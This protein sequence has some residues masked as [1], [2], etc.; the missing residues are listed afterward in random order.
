M[1]FN[2]WYFKKVIIV[3]RPE[4]F[5]EPICAQLTALGQKHMYLPAASLVGV[6]HATPLVADLVVFLSPASVRYAPM[7]QDVACVY[8]VGP[9]TAK[10]VEARFK[11]RCHY[12]SEG[13]YH[14]AGLCQDHGFMDQVKHMRHCIILGG[15]GTE[16]TRF[17]ALKAYVELEF[18]TTHRLLPAITMPNEP[19]PQAGEIWFTSFKLM[20]LFCAHYIDALQL[21]NLLSY[22]IVVPNA[23]CVALA[24]TMGFQQG[25][26]LV[27][28]PTDA[29]FLARLHHD[30]RGTTS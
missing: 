17:Q 16:E 29:M 26:D 8:A 6:S 13:A 19:L 21:K 18:V 5:N 24:Q 28:Q 7:I 23:G 10:A 30:Q 14:V 20:Q 11:V 2:Y 1:S 4:P 22:Q 27:A 12:P 3:T 15:E 25:I 9:Q